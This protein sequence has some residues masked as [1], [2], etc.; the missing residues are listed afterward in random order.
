MSLDRT[1]VINLGGKE[2]KL[3]F[4]IQGVMQLEKMLDSH[5]VYKTVSEQVF[6]L[7]D[8]IKFIY[9]GL[10]A[11]DKS[12]TLEQVMEWIAQWLL[13]NSSNSLQTIVFLAL[14]KSGIL[15]NGRNAAE[16]VGKSDAIDVTADESEE[17]AAGK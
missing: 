13:D 3:K 5:N 4:T 15:G 14:C 10:I 17:P 7:N 12:I 11:I 2:R 16:A 6:S 8:I 9:I 1:T